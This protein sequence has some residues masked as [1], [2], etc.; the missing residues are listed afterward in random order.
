[1]CDVC[2]V[3]KNLIMCDVYRE[4]VQQIIKRKRKIRTLLHASRHV[5]FTFAPGRCEDL[6][7]S[8][9][10]TSEDVKR[11]FMARAPLEEPDRGA[12]IRNLEEEI[13][14]IRMNEMRIA[15]LEREIEEL[16]YRS[17]QSRTRHLLQDNDQKDQSA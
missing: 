17:T 3:P 9:E 6:T 11:I 8:W 12:Y 13:E 10:D 5:H 15:T 16:D 7:L 1:M 2:G 4:I 14:R